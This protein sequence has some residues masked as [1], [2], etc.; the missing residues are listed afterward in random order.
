MQGHRES[1]RFGSGGRI[2]SKG[3]AWVRALLGVSMGKANQ[4]KVNSLGLVVLNNCHR[5]WGI[6]AV[7]TCLVLGPGLT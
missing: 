2:R 4:G 6:G 5:L 1:I 7:S 3:K